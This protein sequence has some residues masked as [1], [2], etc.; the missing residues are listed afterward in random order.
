MHG[1]DCGWLVA[2]VWMCMDF[3]CLAANT[4]DGASMI[5]VSAMGVRF[6]LTTVYDSCD[7]FYTCMLRACEAFWFLVSDYVFYILL[8]YT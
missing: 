7:V 5:F 4:L 3:E 1:L 8:R 2:Y 6:G